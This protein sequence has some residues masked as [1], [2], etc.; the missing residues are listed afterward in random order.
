MLFLG[1]LGILGNLGELG[2]DLEGVALGAEP[3]DRGGQGGAELVDR[4]QRVVEGDDGAVARE[5]LDI[6]DHIL[7]R[8]PLGIV[9]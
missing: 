2:E 7:C 8:Q 4:L 9:A 6:V 1:V 3:L 5:L